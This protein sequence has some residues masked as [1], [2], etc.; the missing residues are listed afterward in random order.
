MAGRRYGV[1]YRDV[2]F[3]F[4][5]V[6]AVLTAG[7]PLYPDTF[8]RAG[9]FLCSF[10]FSEGVEP[11]YVIKVEGSDGFQYG[12]SFFLAVWIIIRYIH[13]RFDEVDLTFIYGK[14]VPVEIAAAFFI[15]FRAHELIFAVRDP[16]MILFR[17]YQF[18]KS[19]I[20]IQILIEFYLR[21]CGIMP[22]DH[23]VLVIGFIVEFPELYPCDLLALHD[24][25][26]HI[27]QRFGVFAR[28]EGFHV[29]GVFELFYREELIGKNFLERVV[30]YSEFIIHAVI[31]TV[32]RDV[33]LPVSEAGN[34][35]YRVLLPRSHP[36]RHI[37]SW[38]RFLLPSCLLSA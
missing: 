35:I 15:V 2:T 22:T 23:Y 30:F 24:L 13:G 19:V 1:L 37:R 9:G 36:R 3:T 34:E 18:S 33:E 25:Y 28:L 20:I 17:I 32:D 4:F 31:R 5:V 6:D 11:V 26:V 10:P 8:F 29:N 12:I 21:I 27:V 38:F 16:Y 14:G 7:T